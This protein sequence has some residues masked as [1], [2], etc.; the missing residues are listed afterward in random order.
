MNSRRDFLKFLA[1]GAGGMVIDPE[2]LLWK[3]DAKKIFIMGVPEGMSSLD[4]INMEMMR[5]VP[6]IR[7]LFER[8]DLFY[9]ALKTKEPI[10]ISGGAM[11][12]IPIIKGD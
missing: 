6:R 1:M 5:L 9:Q 3:P 10:I 4:I 2:L 7:D 12:S 8:D 11:N